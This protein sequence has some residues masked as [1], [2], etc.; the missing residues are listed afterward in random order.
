MGVPVNEL[1]VNIVL[2][3]M[4]QKAV[5]I[6]LALFNLGIQNIYLGPNPPEFVNEAI[7]EFLQQNFNLHLTGD[8]KTDLATM[9]NGQI[10]TAAV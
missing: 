5:L 3:W 10:E 9:L 4:E 1:P 8:A 6:L 7:F 2:S